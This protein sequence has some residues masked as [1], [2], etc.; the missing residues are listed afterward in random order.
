MTFLK[1]L[2]ERGLTCVEESGLYSA[3][4]FAA[5]LRGQAEGTS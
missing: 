4:Y 1:M 2:K 5:H 3:F